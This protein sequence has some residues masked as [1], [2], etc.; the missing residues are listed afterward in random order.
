MAHLTNSRVVRNNW[1]VQHYL[2]L[3]IQ[4]YPVWLA[5][6]LALTLS[7]HHFA[8][9]QRLAGRNTVSSLSTEQICQPPCQPTGGVIYISTCYYHVTLLNLQILQETRVY[10]HYVSVNCRSKYFK[11]YSM[12]LKYAG[13]IIS[14]LIAERCWVCTLLYRFCI[15]LYILYRYNEAKRRAHLT[16]CAQ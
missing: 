7:S 15:V 11:N 1:V 8:A 13:M 3:N 2:Y 14:T 10:R 4:R 12:N 6:A 9:R 5:N 16:N